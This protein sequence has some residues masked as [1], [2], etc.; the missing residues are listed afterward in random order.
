MLAVA[1]VIQYWLS[2]T[3]CW[4]T[5]KERRKIACKEGSSFIIVSFVEESLLVFY[6]PQVNLLMSADSGQH[7]RNY[8][9]DSWAEVPFVYEILGFVKV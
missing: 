6:I 5:L 1:P 2:L 9:R 7:K 3:I 8:I 4:R